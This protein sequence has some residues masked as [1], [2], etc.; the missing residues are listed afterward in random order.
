MPKWTLVG[1]IHMM[2]PL[3]IPW[4]Y[5][6]KSSIWDSHVLLIGT[7]FRICYIVVNPLQLPFKWHLNRLVDSGQIVSLYLLSYTL[8]LYCLP[9]QA[10]QPVRSMPG[11][12]DS[13]GLLNKFCRTL[14]LS[15]LTNC[16]FY[17][18]P[19]T[20]KDKKRN[21]QIL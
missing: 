9:W 4:R 8:Q 10:K 1:L 14:F 12:I 15:L 11:G 19:L 2:A 16:I 7:C 5:H 21:L 20:F 6:R 3:S 17:P 18:F 13:L